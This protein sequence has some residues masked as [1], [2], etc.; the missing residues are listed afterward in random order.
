MLRLRLRSR[1]GSM[2]RI[3]SINPNDDLNS[4]RNT[5][6]AALG[7]TANAQLE[8][9]LADEVS[10]GLEIPSLDVLRDDDAIVARAPHMK[11]NCETSSNELRRARLAEMANEAC[12][13][14]SPLADIAVPPEGAEVDLEQVMVIYQALTSVAGGVDGVTLLSR[15][16]ATDL[17]GSGDV[18]AEE[19]AA[20]DGFAHDLVGKI[21]EGLLSVS[22]VQ[23]LFFSILFTFCFTEM[24][25][26]YDDTTEVGAWTWWYYF[27]A[28]NTFFALCVGT[29]A[30]SLQ[31]VLYSVMTYLNVAVYLSDNL[32]RIQ[33]LLR[34]PKLIS[35]VG[36]SGVT[37]S[38]D[39]ILFIIVSGAACLGVWK[40]VVAIV[41]VLAVYCWAGMIFGNDLGTF[42]SVTALRNA[43]HTIERSAKRRGG[44]GRGEEGVAW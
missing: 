9:R 43:Q 23:T 4:F 37:Q 42:I 20:F 14:L 27:I 41:L 1:D 10:G 12:K 15:V 33:F 2:H 26:D 38:G 3:V 30:Y 6:A 34:F 21:A 22:V 32:E 5:C 28:S 11:V 8:L 18:S 39:L 29:A 13:T 44:R 16:A 19:M 7:L 40:G 31:N 35:W 36:T 25:P 24:A 17:D